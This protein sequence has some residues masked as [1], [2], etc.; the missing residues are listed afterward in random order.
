[1]HWPPTDRRAELSGQAD[2]DVSFA[3]WHTVVPDRIR[4]ILKSFHYSTFLVRISN[5]KNSFFGSLNVELVW[6]SFLDLITGT[7]VETTSDV[8]FIKLRTNVPLKTCFDISQLTVFKTTL[9]DV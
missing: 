3:I 1:M 7:A 4:P 5:E 6:L 2:L 9:P 8:V